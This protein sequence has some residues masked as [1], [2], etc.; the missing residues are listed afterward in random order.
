ML[1]LLI[2]SL[3]INNLA[4]KRI[5]TIIIF[6]LSSKKAKVKKKKL[7]NAIFFENN[8]LAIP[9]DHRYDTLHMDYIFNTL[10]KIINGY[11]YD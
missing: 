8:L 9:I 1:P 7:P 6:N 5:L 11:N 3:A 10:K 2:A 4:A